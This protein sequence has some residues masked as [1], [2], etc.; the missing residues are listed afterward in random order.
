MCEFPNAVK[1]ANYIQ[2]G[3]SEGVRRMWSSVNS[4]EKEI[5]MAVLFTAQANISMSQDMKGC[6]SGLL[7][8]EA[9]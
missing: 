7:S 1:L 9:A 2:A 6:I 4:G 8:K 5:M 3:N